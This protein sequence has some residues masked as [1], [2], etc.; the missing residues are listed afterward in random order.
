VDVDEVDAGDIAVVS[1][2]S[3]VAIGET[4]ADVD[5]PQA[6]PIITV[7]EPTVRMTFGVNTSPLS[8]SEGRWG[9]SRR[10]RQRLFDE[11]RHDMA[12]RVVETDS[13]DTFEVSG[14]G[15]LHLAILIENMRREGYELTI[16]RPRVI[17][18]TL[19]GVRHE[20]V[21][22]LIVD[23]PDFATGAVIELIGPRQ[24][25]M[26]RMQ[27]AAGRTVLEFVIPTRGLIGLR[28]RIV[29]ASRGEAIIHHRFLRYEPVRGDI[30]QRIN[31]ALISMEDGRA[32]AYALD[33]LQDR[34]RFFVDPG[35]HCY[36]G[37]I[38]GEH[39]KD[40]DLVVNIQRAKKLTN[41]RAAGADR[42]LFYAP[43]T[44]LSLEEALEYINADELV[45][46][47][48]EAIRLRKYYLSEVERRRQ[49]DRDWTCE[50]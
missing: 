42:K 35:E 40:S 24:G 29:T 16:S 27:S 33:G 15:E 50:E 44:R 48:P 23:T 8:G 2:L 19:N 49:R 25:A 7:E 34:G 28:T 31:G 13:P 46:A 12:L 20:P 38:V 14:R 22:I 18:K 10:L 32:N 45:E 37:Q 30:P 39:N 43:A 47:T 4:L 3:D 5:D 26:Q 6:L 17:V 36:A 11:L 9:T 1:G 21:E 41:I